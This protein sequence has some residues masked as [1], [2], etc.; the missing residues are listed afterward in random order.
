MSDA[1]AVPDTKHPIVV[2]AH[3]LEFKAAS[4]VWALAGA[5]V[6]EGV[7]PAGMGVG[8]ATAAILRGQ[9]LGL[10]AI[11]SLTNIIV[12]KGRTQMSGSLVLALIRRSGAL[13][14]LTYWWDGDGNTRTAYVK[15]RRQEEPKPTIHVFSMGDAARAGLASKDTYRQ[16]Q[17]DML[18]WRAVARCGRRQFPDVCAGVYVPGEVHGLEEGTPAEPEPRTLPPPAHD[19]LLDEVVG[20]VEFSER[21]EV[22]IP[23]DDDPAAVP[24]AVLDAQK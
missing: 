19:P 6:K 23:L 16:W 10:D 24:D 1:L 22:E 2:G 12:V 13:A 3:G 11:T 21:S 14:E 7:A 15:A 18:L 4:E 8:A 5:L 20:P 9:A 17:D